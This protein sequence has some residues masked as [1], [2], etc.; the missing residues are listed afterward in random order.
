MDAGLDMRCLPLSIPLAV[1]HPRVLAR[2]A[3]FPSASSSSSNAR[4]G[5]KDGEGEEEDG[6]GEGEEEGESVLLL[7][8]TAAEERAAAATMVRMMELHGLC[9]AF[10]SSS[11]P[12]NIGGAQTMTL[13]SRDWRLL[14]CHALGPM[15]PPQ[16]FA[17]LGAAASGAQALLAFVRVGVEAHAQRTAKDF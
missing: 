2:T 16:L 12:T 5:G 13:D 3:A 8:P 10:S 9:D 15:H 17:A 1:M 11:H 4:V 7:D 6:Q 14:A